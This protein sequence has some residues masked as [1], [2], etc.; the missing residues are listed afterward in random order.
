MPI[1][2]LL[3]ALT[4]LA[5][6][7]AVAPVT[8]RTPLFHDAAAG[9]GLRFVHD[10][11]ATGQFYLPEIMGSGAALF[12]YD[13]DGDLDVFLVQGG[14]IGR[15]A[16][17]PALSLSKGPALSPSKGP[18]LSRSKGSRLFR[19]DLVPGGVL[20]FTD[21]TAQAGLALRAVGMGAAVGDYDADGWLDLYVT[22]FGSNALFHNNGNGTFTDVTAAAGVDDTRW[23][24]SATF[25]DYDRDGDLDLFVANYVG[26]TVP[27]NKV[28]TDPVGVRDYCA[29]ASYPPAPDHLFRNE[30]GGRFT[31]ASERAGITRAY[32]AGLGVATGDFNGDGWPDL[33]VANDATPNQLWINR[34]DGTFEDTGLISGTALNA[35][36]RPEGSMGIAAG[37]A[38]NDG[39]EDLFVTNLVGETYVLY[40]NDGHGGF[41]DARARSGLAAPTAAMTGF[42]AAWLDYDND[43]LLDLFVANGAV[44]VIESER[45][46]PRPFRQPNQLFRH[47]TGLAWRDVSDEAGLRGRAEV[48]RGVAVGDVDNDGDQ[49][50][51]VTTNGGPVELLLNGAGATAPHAHWVELSLKPAA[52]AAGAPG[53]LVRATV[54]GGPALVRRA[55]TDG[56]Y[57]SAGDARVHV[58]LGATPLEFVDVT[59][60]GGR[61]ER[62]VPPLDRITVLEEGRGK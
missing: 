10:N 24:T 39:D 32:G 22:A 2:S 8:T 51:L 42:G 31:D 47:E 53:A 1:R 18:A 35:A 5:I 52:G 34:K 20:H 17:D 26:F 4:A 25:V 40:L 23:S 45:G 60:P 6:G 15:V 55:H 50:V 12:D 48:Y 62:F 16:S 41:D 44:N 46:E 38:D 59:W 19:N 30:G 54:S 27:G 29:P 37:D 11:G 33:Y 13:N 21:V 57:L 3:A 43:G 56:S 9:T 49:D 36:G 58:G 7:T 14:A 28:C 61:S